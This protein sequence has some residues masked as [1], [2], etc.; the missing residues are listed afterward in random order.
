[1]QINR[2]F[3]ITYILLNK[4]TVT[5]KELAERFLVSTRTIYR[6]ID[7]I[8]LAGIPVYTEKGKSGGIS[9]LPDFVLDKSILSE[10][11]Q[12]EILSA[13]HSLSNIKTEETKQILNK[14]SSIFNKTAANWLEVDFS[15]WGFENDFFNG[16][17]TAITERRIAEFDYYNSYGEKFFRRV[18]PIQLWFKSMSWYL[19]GFCL[20]KQEM[21]LYKLSRIKN[22]AV[23]DSRFSVRDL[24]TA[25]E[26]L[27]RDNRQG[28]KDVMLK[29]HI[30]PE[31]AYR[32]FDDFY[33]SMVEKQPDGS[34]IVK[35]LWPEDNWLYGFILSFGEFAEVLEPEYI[36]KIIKDKAEKISKLY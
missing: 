8:S 17:K 26:D 32:V 21:R 3:E 14:L 5:A 29:L 28:Q 18:E 35:V 1:M 4:R 22:L 13:L 9:L 11:E 6:D 23:T 30:K 19:K 2:L 16:F 10:R 25:S 34:F 12:N 15:G 33:E 36:R 31:M 7:A 20:T 27:F 24:D